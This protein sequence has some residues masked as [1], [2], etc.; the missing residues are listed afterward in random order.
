[1]ALILLAVHEGFSGFIMT[2]EAADFLAL[3]HGAA[4]AHARSTPTSWW[5]GATQFVREMAQEMSYWAAWP[6]LARRRCPRRR[7]SRRTRP[8]AERLLGSALH[9]AARRPGPR[10]GRAPPSQRRPA[11]SPTLASLSRYETRKR[12]LDVADSSRLILATGLVVPATDLEAWLGGWTRRDLLGFLASV[13]RRA[14]EL[15]E[16]GA[17]GGGGARRSALSCCGQRM[18][19]SGVVELR[20]STRRALGCSGST[21]RR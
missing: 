17:A 13:R 9:A 5:S 21:S 2:G 15:L 10:G 18:A 7:S 16:Q 6:P 20:R 8:H 11:A 19:E 4:R 3:G 1:M 14:R 12:G